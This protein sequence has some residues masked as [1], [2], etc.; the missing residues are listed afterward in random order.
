MYRRTKNIHEVGIG[1]NT[2]ELELPI[3][4]ESWE[5]PEIKE[6]IT[7]SYILLGYLVHDSDCQNP[8]ESC[9]AMGVIHHHPRSRYGSR[10]S[11]YYEVLGLDNYGDPSPDEDKV[12]MLW[13]DRVMA[14]P[15]E[16]FVFSEAFEAPGPMQYPSSK[17]EP[18]PYNLV[19]QEMLADQEAGDYNLW[20]MAKSAWCHYSDFSVEA[21]EDI[22]SRIEEHMSWDWE[23]V[24]QLC[25]TADVDAVLLDRYEHG[26]CSYSVHS[27]G[28]CPW[29]TS[30]GEAVWVP[31]KY[32]R[33]ELEQIPDPDERRKQAVKYANQAC[34]I[35]TDWAN[36][37][38]Y[39]WVVGVFD[40]VD[41]GLVKEESCWGFIDDEY[42]E[43][44]LESTMKYYAEKYAQRLPS[45]NQA[46]LTL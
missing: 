45:P 12:Q 37:N 6:I 23:E 26:M 43:E 15:S 21:M 16:L 2:L 8:L 1:E 17:S 40:K 3:T 25:H 44:E 4:L 39:G 14:I 11:D 19:L 35:Y 34:D 9:D 22:V 20:Q 33:Q 42:A 28:G 18:R 27:N 10:D 5:D 46:E 41:G 38:S 7:E 31:D 32:L 13:R 36:G 30:R 24:L 29:D